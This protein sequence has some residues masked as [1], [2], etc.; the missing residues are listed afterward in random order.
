MGLNSNKY[1]IAIQA[2]SN[3]QIANNYESDRPY[4]TTV[5]VGKHLNI[6]NIK[7]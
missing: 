1:I 4:T 3:E 2:T 5:H 7:I 6:L